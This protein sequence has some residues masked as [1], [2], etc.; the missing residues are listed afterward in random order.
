MITLATIIAA[1]A[2]GVAIG[3]LSSKANKNSMGAK[4]V[5]KL[6]LPTPPP[7]P[8]PSVI[9][10]KSEPK[11]ERPTVSSKSDVKDIRSAYE[12]LCYRT[13][14]LDRLTDACNPV[15]ELDA[16]IKENMVDLRDCEGLVCS[17]GINLLQY[18]VDPNDGHK[19]SLI[20]MKSP[21]AIMEYRYNLKGVRE[22]IGQ[23]WWKITE[24][25]IHKMGS[26]EMFG[27]YSAI[28][29]NGDLSAKHNGPI[30]CGMCHEQFIPKCESVDD[31]ISDFR[32]ETNYP[33][34]YAF[35]DV[36]NYNVDQFRIQFSGCYTYALTDDDEV[37][38]VSETGLFHESLVFGGRYL[39]DY[40]KSIGI[41]NFLFNHRKEIV[42]AK[43]YGARCNT[44]NLTFVAFP[45]Q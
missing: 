30:R 13:D 3:R 17:D 4:P 23:K 40:I 37:Y 11:P 25:I 6:A 26:K 24:D 36:V 41:S 34:V 43:S 15:H 9:P 35:K 16:F 2:V 27:I 21:N 39:D 10:V 45:K 18:A 22:R 7:I 33:F 32:K 19:F 31:P 12:Y 1:G 44:L 42:A 5:A 28:Y 20:R 38:M 29:G 8:Q 14:A